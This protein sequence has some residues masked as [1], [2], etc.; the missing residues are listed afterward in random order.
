LLKTNIKNAWGSIV[1]VRREMN[2]YFEF[3]EDK[4]EEEKE[5]WKQMLSKYKEIHK[6][7]K[8][9][10][11]TE[12][13]KAYEMFHC[14][15][16]G[17]PQIQW[18]KIVHEMHTKDPWISVNGSSNKGPRVCSWP[19]FLDCIKLHKLTIF[20][21]DATEKQRHYMRQMVKKPQWSTVHQYMAHMGILNNYLTF[22]PTVVNSSMA[23]EGTKKGNVPFNKAY[24]AGIVLNSVPVSWMNQYNMTHF[25]L[26]DGSRTL[27]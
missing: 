18:D 25:T 6:A 7:K 13:Q 8:L 22:L 1:E 11:I 20:P 4:T 19:S 24:L 10:A 12:T 15:V 5:T 27:L 23:V 16:V 14:S 9:F 21:V 26:P 2:P 3:S 17:N